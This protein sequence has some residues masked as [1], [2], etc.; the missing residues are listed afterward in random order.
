MQEQQ[1]NPYPPP[2]EPSQIRPI[3]TGPV[4]CDIAVREPASGKWNLL[5]IFNQV[6]AAR[7]PSQRPLSVYLKLSDAMGSYR[8]ELR[9]VQVATGDQLALASSDIVV[10]DRLASQD[11]A[12][13]FPKIPIPTEGKYEFQVWANGM[14]LGA[15]TFT[16]KPLPGTAPKDDFD[17]D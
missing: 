3:L 5:G 10:K 14:H 4:L 8:L 9:L 16:A 11:I 15:G 17:D 1:S 13:N 6:A 2:E 12:V 7:F